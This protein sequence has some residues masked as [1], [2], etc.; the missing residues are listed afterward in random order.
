[1][2]ATMDAA[3]KHVLGSLP[4]VEVMWG[5]FAFHLIVITAVLRAIGLRPRLRPRAL[6]VQVTRSILLASTNLCFAAA[7]TFIPLAEN[8][9][10]NFLSPIITVGLAAVW[11]HERVGW[12][13]WL[14]LGVGLAG[15][16]AM[17]RPGVTVANPGIALGLCSATIF[18]FYQILTRRLAGVDKPATTIV[19]TGLWA[20]LVISAVVPFFW[21][22]PG[23]Q[24]W[25]ILLV[26]G[27]LGGFGHFLLVLA[28]DRAP[29]SLL[30]PLGYF[31][32]VLAL[33]Y[34]M[35]VFGEV[36]DA[37]MLAG[38]A[39]IIGGGLLVVTAP[40]RRA[41]VPAIAATFHR[42]ATADMSD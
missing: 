38:G 25:A 3:T 1:M 12:Q 19:H 27:T 13:R 5:R 7:L 22:D 17:V 37:A 39:V 15:M 35:F 28:Y 34:G 41:A 31:Q 14:G 10:I 2:F 36:P 18:A 26:I 40:V 33:G 21:I 29:A 8:T 4:V 20:S 9:A 6:P 23:W 11:L 24:G 42:Q 32:L 16:L 30:A